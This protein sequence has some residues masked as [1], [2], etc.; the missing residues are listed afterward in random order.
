[1]NAHFAR[2]SPALS[3]L[4]GNRSSRAERASRR[5]TN[6]RT[7]AYRRSDE[8]RLVADCCPDSS[9]R[10]RPVRLRSR[11]SRQAV[12]LDEADCCHMAD[13]ADRQSAPSCCRSPSSDRRTGSRPSPVVRRRQADRWG[14]SPASTSSTAATDRQ[15][16]TDSSASYRS[17]GAIRPTG[18]VGRPRPGA[19]L[20]LPARHLRRWR[21]ISYSHRW[22][23]RRDR[24][25]RAEPRHSAD[26]DEEES[27]R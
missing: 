4:A 9:Q 7:S 22:S 3:H 19:V 8:G 11:R 15:L 5:P 6:T 21:W 23:R 13:G 10:L 24:N 1:L 12:G 16:L 26:L 14:R 25:E 20:G 2:S 18:P 17:R 27:K